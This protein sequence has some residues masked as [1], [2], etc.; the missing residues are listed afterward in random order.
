VTVV[1]VG[2]KMR[3]RKKSHFNKS[4]L[5]TEALRLRVVIAR[6]SPYHHTVLRLGLYA[7]LSGRLTGGTPNVW[8]KMPT[9]DS[10]VS[11]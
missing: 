1:V 4:N 5:R 8:P 11:K 9:Y 7:G 2:G 3:R 6:P 10:S